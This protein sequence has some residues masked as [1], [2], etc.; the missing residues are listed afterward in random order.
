MVFIELYVLR[1]LKLRKWGER[2]TK[3]REFLDAIPR[4]LLE[5]VDRCLIV[6]PRRRI[7]AED[8]LKHEFFYPVHETLRNQMLLKQQQ[9]Q[10]QPTV[11]ADALSETLN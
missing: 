8:A 4:P 11:V 7:S 9:M 6:N 2:N 10:S 3:S 1:Y 5:L